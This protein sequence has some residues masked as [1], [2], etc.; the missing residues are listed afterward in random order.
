MDHADEWLK[1]AERESERELREVLA[2]AL[3]AASLEP[4]EE[5]KVEALGPDAYGLMERL[6]QRLI[7]LEQ[8]LERHRASV[9]QKLQ[10][11]PLSRL[12]GIDRRLKILEARARFEDSRKGR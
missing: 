8:G 12:E 7:S 6:E 3:G 1:R 9:D 5:V 2:D 10:D 11:A 4:D